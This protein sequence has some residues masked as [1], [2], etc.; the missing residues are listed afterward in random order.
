MKRY[1]FF[2]LLLS[3]TS[4]FGHIN[5]GDEN[6]FSRKQAN[7]AAVLR[8]TLT[9]NSES[10]L[11]E[12]SSDKTAKQELSNYDFFGINYTADFNNAG[13]GVLGFEGQ[14]LGLWLNTI[15]FSLGIG[16][17]L[18]LKNGYVQ[19]RLGPNFGIPLTKIVFIYAPVEGLV[20][21]VLSG[22]G[23]DQKWKTAWGIQARP[24]IGLKFGKF[25]I[26][27]G[28]SIGWVEKADKVSTGFT[29]SIGYDF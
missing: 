25:A 15:G 13:K 27:T 5:V 23:N 7:E 18:P 16:Y 28:I 4:T 9:R 2:F 29:A 1:Y 19:F 22:S 3:A 17:G 10:L 24:S 8:P 12:S 26:S 11:L 21:C 14:A 20:N 6:E